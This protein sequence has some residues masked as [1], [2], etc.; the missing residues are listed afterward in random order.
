MD[1]TRSPIAELELEEIAAGGKMPDEI[2]A[3]YA[4][5]FGTGVGAALYSI[6]A[7]HQE[8]GG[9]KK[10]VDA[11]YHDGEDFVIKMPE[12]GKRF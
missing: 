12:T 8:R 2:R 5:L 11:I 10:L 1:D 7:E 4:F 3:A 6:R 9:A